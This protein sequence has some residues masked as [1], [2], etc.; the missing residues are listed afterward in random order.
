VK[1][2]TD[3]ED[4]VVRE[5]ILRVA[6]TSEDTDDFEI[7]SDCKRRFLNLVNIFPSRR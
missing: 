5:L 4:E 7:N 1:P 3:K 2:A 6:D